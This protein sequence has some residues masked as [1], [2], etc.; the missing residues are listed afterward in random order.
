MGVDRNIPHRYRPESR[1]ATKPSSCASKN[2]STPCRYQSWRDVTGNEGN[3]LPRRAIRERPSPWWERVRACQLRCD[4]VNRPS[5][6]GRLR[7]R[8]EQTEYQL[9]LSCG[10]SPP[11]STQQNI[12]APVMC[13]VFCAFGIPSC[14]DAA[15]RFVFGHRDRQMVLLGLLAGFRKI[16][17]GE[18]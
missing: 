6:R 12:T 7:Q 15:L 10:R 2:P 17:E 9:F 13:F 8:C 1:L 5:A 4:R 18:I 11:K 16:P 3:R 14:S